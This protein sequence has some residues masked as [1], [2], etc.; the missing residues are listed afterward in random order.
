MKYIFQKKLQVGDIWPQ[1]VNFWPNLKTLDQF[2]FWFSYLKLVFNYHFH[3]NVTRSTQKLQF[4]RFLTLK[5]VP[6]RNYPKSEV[7]GQFFKNSFNGFPDFAYDYRWARCLSTETIELNFFWQE[8]VMNMTPNIFNICVGVG[9]G[10]KQNFGWFSDLMVWRIFGIKKISCQEKLLN[11]NY[12]SFIYRS[13]T[14]CYLLLLNQMTFFINSLSSSSGSS[15]LF[16][17]TP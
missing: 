10:V 7:F 1:V 6:K 11:H 14:N 8:I 12:F 3:M 15:A 5:M 2:F 16:G 4:P 17:R 13:K 9:K